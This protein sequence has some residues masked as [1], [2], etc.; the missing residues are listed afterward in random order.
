[1][2]PTYER[3]NTVGPPASQAVV[4]GGGMAGMLAT[5]ALARHLDR[6][7]LIERDA[8]PSRPQARRGLPQ[9]RH[10][11]I[12]L[13]TGVQAIEALLP[14]TL[15][16]LL[17]A[18]AQRRG[19]PNELL[20]FTPQG[21]L[22]RWPETQY[23]IGCSRDLLDWVIR[24]RLQQHPRIT[25]R[26]G[27]TAT[28]ITGSA[29]RITGVRL[30]NEHTSQAFTMTADLVV[31]A[32][33]RS[34]RMPH[35]LATRGL[36]TVRE[37][38]VASGLTYVTRVFRAPD[39]ARDFPVVNIAAAPGEH[40]YGQAGALLPIE[41]G[42]W[43]VTLAGTRGGEPPTARGGFTAFARQLRHRLIGDLIADAEPL[44]SAHVSRSTANRRRAYENLKRWPDG[45]LV[46]GDATAA[47]NPIYA[48]GMTVAAL[49]AVA[50]D[51]HL[52]RHGV[53]P[54]TTR[55]AQRAIARPVT[56]AWSVATGQDRLLVGTDG[57]RPTVTDHLAQHGAAQLMRAA[58]AHPA[59]AEA[60]FGVLTLAHSPVRLLTPKALLAT[61]IGFRHQQLTEP[62]LTQW[63]QSFLA[64]A[65]SG[66]QHLRDGT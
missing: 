32:T 6:V 35:W 19:M 13:S 43:L 51:R 37:T 25:L 59:A 49:G 54:G 38:T 57:P 61:L 15:R 63:E 2:T 46:L 12:L 52:A 24:Q 45:L 50:L 17:D 1:M 20:S 33:G 62:P 48:Q 44:G 66:E 55:R 34:S 14:G 22:R 39:G 36:P 18:G 29:D 27:L 42:R 21:W 8:F 31:D 4:L 53:L 10:T 64:T 26:P 56:V 65:G 40:H 5:A 58:A 7:I 30:L 41:G 60:F 28:G 9:A 3:K 11:H 23:V 16:R 47:F